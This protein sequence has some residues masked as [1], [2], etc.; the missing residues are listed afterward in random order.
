MSQNDMSI[1]NQTFPNTRTDINSALQALAST[2][3][4]TSAPSTTYANQFWYDTSA[5]TLYIRNEDNDANITVAVLDQTNDTVEYF[6]SDSIRTTLLEYTDGD[7]ALTINDGGSLTTAGNLSVG[8]SNNELRFYEGSN[9]VGFEAPALT[10]DKIWVLPTGDG[11]ANQALVTDGSGTLSWAT[12]GQSLRPNDLPLVMNGEMSIVQ[13]GNK[14]GIT[15]TQYA[16]DRWALQCSNFGTWSMSQDGDVPT[17]KGYIKSVKLDNTTADGSLAAGDYGI[18]RTAWE[19]SDLQFLKKGSS[20]A[21]ALTLK[22]WVRSSDTG[23]YVV[24]LYDTD[25]TRHIAKTYAISSANTW[26]EKVINFAGDTT[27]AFTNDFN[28]S[29]VMN[30]WLGSGTTYTSGTLATSWASVTNGNRAAG[31]NVNLAD[32]TANDIYFTGLQLEVGTFTSDTIPDFQHEFYASSR[33]RCQRYYIG[34][35]DLVPV[36][37]VT[38]GTTVQGLPQFR[39]EMRTAPTVT[40]V[41]VGGFGLIG[42]SFTTSSLAGSNMGVNGGRYISNIDS[43]LTVNQLVQ[44]GLPC[45]LFAELLAQS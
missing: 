38:T 36:A 6:K 2:S 3:S 17:G 7:D 5:N 30:F 11:S 31:L 45:T 39:T 35:Q 29:L 41:A 4:G 24:E 44:L 28:E 15:G 13:Y 32:N 18:F 19:G 20:S 34:D 25:N 37:Q 16:C 43:T 1:A 9:Y 22:F 33:T 21:E 14:T 40:H 42:G 8:G 10:G 26:E 27:G 12:A 23:T